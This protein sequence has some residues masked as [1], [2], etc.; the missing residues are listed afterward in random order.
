MLI[1]IKIGTKI[2]HMQAG[3]TNIYIYTKFNVGNYLQ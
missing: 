1:K 3:K 2:F